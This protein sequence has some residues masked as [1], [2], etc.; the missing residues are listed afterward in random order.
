ME[1]SSLDVMQSLRSPGALCSGGHYEQA[2]AEVRDLWDGLPTN[3]VEVSNA[4]MILEYAVAILMQLGRLNEA[5]EWAERGLDFREKRHD[6]GEAEFLIAK[7]AYEQG[8]LGEAYQ[9]FATAS[10]KSNGRILHGEDPMYR[11]LISR[12]IEG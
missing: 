10:K 3:K 6:L 1:N 2:L 12:P 7:V 4:Y 5:H 8:N 11:A 9:L